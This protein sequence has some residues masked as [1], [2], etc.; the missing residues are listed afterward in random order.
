MSR[1]FSFKSRK[2]I[3]AKIGDKG[4]PIGVSKIW[5]YILLL[6]V[7]KVVVKINFSISTN[8]TYGMLILIE[9]KVHLFQYCWLQDLVKCS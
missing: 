4:H 3:S 7:K 2:T 8:S 5:L 6:K 9:I 1:A